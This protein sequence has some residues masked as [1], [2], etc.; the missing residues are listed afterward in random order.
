MYMP[1]RFERQE[2]EPVVRV[3]VVI[4]G[5]A[6]RGRARHAEAGRVVS[7]AGRVD[8]AGRWEAP[9]QR[10]A[11]GRV[12]VLV[13]TAARRRGGVGRPSGRGR[14]ADAAKQQRALEDKASDAAVDTLGAAAAAVDARRADVSVAAARR[15]RGCRA[16]RLLLLRR[17]RRRRRRHVK[18]LFHLVEHQREVALLLDQCLRLVALMPPLARAPRRHCA[19]S[20]L[21]YRGGFS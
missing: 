5:V 4:V 21:S 15:R 18:Q 1:R 19:R 3:V 13:A 17:R 7:V 8:D 10:L 16:L 11:V 2:L 6:A 20:G 14:R 12:V 9:A